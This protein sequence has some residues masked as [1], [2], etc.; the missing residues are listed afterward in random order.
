MKLYKLFTNIM[1]LSS[2]CLQRVRAQIELGSH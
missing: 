1:E 2:Q